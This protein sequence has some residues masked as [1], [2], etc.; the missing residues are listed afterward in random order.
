MKTRMAVLAVASLTL[1]LADPGRAHWANG[2]RWA[3]GARMAMHLQQGSPAGTLIDGNTSW[4]RVTEDALSA[5]NQVLNSVSFTVVHDSTSDIAPRNNINNIIWAD[6]VYGEPFGDAVAITSYLYTVPGNTMVEADVVFDR[7]R[8][9][10]SYRGNLRR[11]DGGGT[12]Y[13]LHRVAL[14]EFG[15]A[16][17]LGHPDDH[18]QA[19][20]AIM[21]RRVSD[22]DGLQAD[23]IDGIRAI[24]GVRANDTLSSG[25]R[26][27]AGQTLV[28]VNA[29][30]RLLYQGDG[31]LVLYDDVDRTAVWASNTGSQPGQALMQGDGNFV[32][33]DAQGV[34]LWSAGTSGHANARLMVQDDGN[35]VIYSSDG[36]PVWNRLQ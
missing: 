13:D 11:A 2:Q 34:P 22:V 3:A 23:D 33:Y 32:I 27:T 1:W 17:G 30:Y 7:G 14:H 29:R 10:N 25:A 18:E 31:N 9:W 12:L 20:T 26:L 5:W 19:V 28:S 8:S 36:Q 24:Y 15:H 6:D 16:L 21:N 35:L 4:N